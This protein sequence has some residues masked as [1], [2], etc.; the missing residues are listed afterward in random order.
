MNCAGLQ[1]ILKSWFCSQEYLVPPLMKHSF[2]AKSDSVIKY[3]V[4]SE[5]RNFLAG[6]LAI[7]IQ[8]QVK[9]SVCLSSYSPYFVDPKQK[10]RGEKKVRDKT[11]SVQSRKTTS[12]SHSLSTLVVKTAHPEE[13]L[14]EKGLLQQ[15][16]IPQVAHGHIYFN[17]HLH[18]QSCL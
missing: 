5:I 8:R 18:T 1:N 4:H 15:T 11:P 2:A 14:T 6:G 17:L 7:R 13:V 12:F 10:N 3:Q 16:K 9:F